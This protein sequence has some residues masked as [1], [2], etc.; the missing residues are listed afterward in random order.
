MSSFFSLRFCEKLRTL[1]GGATIPTKREMLRLVMSVYDPLG[2]VASFAIHG[3]ILIQEVWRT[4]TDWDTE[5]PVEIATRWFE[6]LAVLKNITGLRISRCYFPG[7]NPEGMKNLELHVFVDASAQAYAAVAYFRIIDRGQIRVIQNEG[8]ATPRTIDSTIRADSS[9][10]W[11]CSWIKS[12]TRRYRQFV[13]FRVD[14]ILSLTNINEWH[15]VPT[16]VYV[17]DEATKWGKGPSCKVDSRWFQG[18]EFHKQT[19]WTMVPENG[20][21]ESHKE[22]R[23]V[24]MC[25][26]YIRKSVIDPERFSRFERMVR[27]V[28]YVHHFV[29]LLRS[30]KGSESMGTVGKTS[31]E[32]QRAENTLWLIAQ[33]EAFPDEVAV[34]RQNFGRN[35]TGQKQ[36]EVS[37]NLAKQPPFVDEHGVLRV[38]SRVADATVL[39]YDTKFPIILPRN[40]RI[41]DLLL[42]FYHRKYGHAND[43]TIVNEV[44]QKFHVSQLRV[45]VRL[46]R[47]RYMWCRVYKTMPAAPKMGLLPAIRL[48]PCVRPFT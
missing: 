20:T 35:D 18:P 25:S 11:I 14:E 43:E 21:D 29:D 24:Y 41:T 38:G 27:S 9:F 1:L 17:A 4:D 22:L 23:E 28:A 30:S 33:S 10:D 13:A 16:K 36:L 12:D 37:S 26:H 45:K 31:A 46:T 40:H 2:L 3:K 34:L 8:R 7:Y 5:I 15:W 42:D 47:K 6:W 19:D 48:E 32:I 44:R 39:A